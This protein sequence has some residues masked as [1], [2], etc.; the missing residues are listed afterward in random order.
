M[1]SDNQC[2]VG[3]DFEVDNH[4][5]FHTFSQ[6]ASDECHGNREV[7]Q[8]TRA[9]CEPSA[10]RICLECYGDTRRHRGKEWSNSDNKLLTESITM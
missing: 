6:P 1:D 4:S 7:S 8:V 2:G 5:T 3:N 10:S 9:G